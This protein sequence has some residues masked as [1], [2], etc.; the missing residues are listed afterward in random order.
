MAQFTE[1]EIKKILETWI[2]EG[3]DPYWCVNR[4]AGGVIVYKAVLVERGNR[5]EGEGPTQLKATANAMLALRGY[6]G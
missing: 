6:I 5:V 1:S 2:V 3:V 4:L